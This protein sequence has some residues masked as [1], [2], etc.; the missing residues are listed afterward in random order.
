M[1][2][3]DISEEY[4]LQVAQLIGMIDAGERRMYEYGEQDE[5]FHGFLCNKMLVNEKETVIGVISAQNYSDYL[6]ISVCFKEDLPTEAYD[7]TRVL[8]CELISAA[9]GNTRIWSRRENVNLISLLYDMYQVKPD[10]ASREM[11]ISKKEFKKWERPSILSDYV[12]REYEAEHHMDYINL[13]DI[14]MWHVTEPGTHPY[15]DDAKYLETY[16]HELSLQ[17]RFHAL[18]KQE[19]LIGICYTDG[20]EI[21][22]IVVDE[23]ERGKDLGYYLLYTGLESVF[24]N[25]EYDLFLYVVD[26][27]N[28][29]LGFYQHCGMRCTAHSVRICV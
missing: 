10:F 29:A 7:V 20:R 9:S 12:M 26:G 13:L 2:W 3:I 23:M 17:K 4:T 5:E 8:L 1:N 16:F 11:S 6:H 25:N 19:R 18:W 22:T 15:L 24:K 14:N 27:N 28:N 21:D